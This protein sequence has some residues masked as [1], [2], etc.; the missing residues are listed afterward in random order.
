MIDES[1][2]AVLQESLGDDGTIIQQLIDLY[3]T[4]SLQQLA[5]AVVA[6]E[7]H[8]IEGLTRAAHSLKSTSASMGATTA[9]EIARE[10]E[11]HAKQHDLSQ[12]VVVLERLRLEVNSAIATFAK[13]KFDA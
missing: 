4:D 3:T 12:S 10:L 9:S 6:I 1:V 11:Q 13:M 8:D 2:I 7:R 5:D